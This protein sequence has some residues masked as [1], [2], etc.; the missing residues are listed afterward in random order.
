M[1]ETFDVV[2]VGSGTG[3]LA[4]IAAADAG[5]R[6]LLVEKTPYLGGSTAISG[7]GVWIPNNP[8]LSAQ[9]VPDSVERAHEYLD[10]LVGDSAPRAR[11][12]AFLRHGPAAV[13]FMCHYVPNSFAPMWGYPDYFTEVPGGSPRGRSIESQPFDA[14]RL[15]Q[16]RALLRDTTLRA[17]VPMPVTSIDYKWMNL[18]TRSPRGSLRIAKRAVQGIGGMAL[19]RE[20]L[21]GG[22]ALAAGLIY[23]ARQA[24][25]TWWLNCP[26]VDFITADSRIVGVVVERNGRL[27]KVA[28]ERGVIVAAG[29]FEHDAQ[30][31]ASYQSVVLDGSWSMGSEGNTGDLHKLATAQGAALSF[32]DQAWWF[33]VIATPKGPGVLLSDRSLPGSFIVDSAGKRFMNESID[34][35]RAGQIML[36]HTDGA[37][38]RVP[39]WMIFDQAYRNKYMFSAVIPPRIDLPKSWY[40]AKTAFKAASLEQ[41]GRL[42]NA[43]CLA[44]TASRFNLMAAQGHD[45]DFERGLSL[46]DHFYGDPSVTPNPNLAPVATAP[47]YAVKVVPGD[48]GT[49]GGIAADEYGRALRTDGSVLPGLYAIGN[50]AANVFGSYYPGPGCTIGQGLVYGYIAARHAA[51]MP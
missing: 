24:G 4:A 31:R 29:G 1:N 17:P 14:R 38:P 35:M 7:G 50:A 25:V 8:V 37:A 30:L 15:G 21:A 19:G 34:Y 41:L 51:R 45:D 49:C 44:R 28:A 23:G 47:F 16:D 5:M 11:W 2:I 27:T 6:T 39:S 46:Y 3:M 43:P 48:L 18:L 40:E 22:Q 32:M 10:N 12:K 42:I 36:G 20:Y 9:K 13:G 26:V 33:P